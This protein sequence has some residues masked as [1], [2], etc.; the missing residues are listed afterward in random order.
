MNVLEKSVKVKIILLIY[1][2]TITISLLLLTD[3][4]KFVFLKI[5]LVQGAVVYK[6]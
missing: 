1:K 3:A 2:Q 4:F 5:T 6:K